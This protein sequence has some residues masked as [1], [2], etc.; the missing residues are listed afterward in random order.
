MSNMTRI[1]GI[2]GN[3]ATGKSVVRRMLANLGALGVDADDVAHR[4]IYPGGPAYQ[5][6]LE[7]FGEGI[8][9][10]QGRIA[11]PRLGKIVFQNPQKLQQLEA[12]IHPAV[13]RAIQARLDRAAAP[14]AAVEAIKLLESDL[15]EL[16]DQV[17]VSHASEARQMARLVQTRGL[18][19]E[20]AQHRMD[21][22]PPQAQKLACADV[23]I[24]TEGSFVDTWTQI[25]RALN[26]TIQL[27]TNEPQPWPATALRACQ[28]L[29][30]AQGKRHS[31]YQALGSQ[32]LLPLMVEDRLAALAIWQDGNFTA[33]LTEVLPPGGWDTDALLQAFQAQAEGQAC[34]CLFLPNGLADDPR[35][36][37]Y[38]QMPPAR[39]GYPAWVTAGERSLAQ[40]ESEIWAKALAQPVESRLGQAED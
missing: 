35:Q 8:L 26:D 6:V 9:D 40:G 20:D 37:G 11:R 27:K 32:M 33:A 22:Q 25:R 3:I 15:A 36:H 4:V 12:I 29:W 7:A 5:P 31:L 38:V 13:T 28:E 24:T 30:K 17:W 14:L 23:V 21:A 19:T 34:E 1:I 10:E 18:S 16:C 2:T 39:L